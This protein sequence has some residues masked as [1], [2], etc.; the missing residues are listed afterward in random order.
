MLTVV[1]WS[2]RVNDD[3]VVVVSNRINEDIPNDHSKISHN[4]S[5][6]D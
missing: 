1:I 5:I 3:G 2:G 6:S 4:Y